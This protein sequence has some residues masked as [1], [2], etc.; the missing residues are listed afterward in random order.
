MDCA[1][2][3]FGRGPRE[4]GGSVDL[5]KQ[6]KLWPHHEFFCK[7]PLPIEISDTRYLRNIIGEAKIKKGEG[8]ELDQLFQN[9]SGV[10]NRHQDL[11]PFD[12]VILREAFKMRETTDA[13]LSYVEK[14]T[15]RQMPEMCGNSTDKIL[16]NHKIRDKEK[17]K[18][19]TC[20]HHRKDSANRK[21]DEKTRKSHRDINTNNLQKLQDKKRKFEGVDISS[22]QRGRKTELDNLKA[23][24][25]DTRI[26]R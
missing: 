25:V 15:G 22:I 10:E 2:T 24:I 5:I 6:C 14:G 17:S 26:A 12:M 1:D 9:A 11:H 4:L 18:D 13:D 16:E 3:K 20:Q 19:H 21:D 7:R 23:K 8:M